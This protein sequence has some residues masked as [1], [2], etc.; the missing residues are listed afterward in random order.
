[1][2]LGPQKIEEITRDKYRDERLGTGKSV[3]GT[4]SRDF[5]R[6]VFSSNNPPLGPDSWAKAVSNMASNSPR[7]SSRKPTFFVIVPH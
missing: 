3:K 6:S 7:K 2:L 4:V 1:M 5:Q